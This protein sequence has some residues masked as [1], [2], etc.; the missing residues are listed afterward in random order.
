MQ[1]FN[2][3]IENLIGEGASDFEISKLF[4]GEIRT[5]LEDIDTY[6]DKDSYFGESSDLWK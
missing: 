1:S 5:Y 4:K 2:E 6:Y 3:K